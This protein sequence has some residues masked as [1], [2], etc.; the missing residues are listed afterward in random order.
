VPI[1]SDKY[2]KNLS[3]KFTVSNQNDGDCAMF[4]VLIMKSHHDDV[5]E[6]FARAYNTST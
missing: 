5:F 2:R 4:D 6:Y 3:K 1:T